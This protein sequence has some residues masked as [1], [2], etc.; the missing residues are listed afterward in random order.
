MKAIITY[1][2]ISMVGSLSLMAQDS[3]SLQQAILTGLENNFQIR[4]SELEHEIAENDNSWGNAGRY[5][6]IAFNFNS[7]NSSTEMLDSVGVVVDGESYMVKYD[8]QQRFAQ[9]VSVGLNWTVFNGFRVNITK[10]KL[11]DLERISEGNA[12]I[13]VENTLQ[14]ILLA[15]YGALLQKEALDVLEEVKTLSRDRYNYEL[16]RKQFGTAV[17][18]DVLQ[19]QNN[20]LSDSAN[21][22]NQQI[23]YKNALRNLNLVL[24]EPIDK[25]YELSSRFDVREEEFVMADLIT[26]LESSNKTLQNQFINQEILKKNVKLN[27]S[28]LYPVVSIN[29]NLSQSFVGS[30]GDYEKGVWNNPYMYDVNLALSYTLSDGGNVRRAIHNARINQEIGELRLEDMRRSLYNQLFKTLEQYEIKKQL[31]HVSETSIESA[32]LNLQIA[33]EKYRSGAISS[34][35]YRDIQI[36]YLNAARDLIQSNYNLIDSH[37][38]LMRL[39][40][41]IVTEYGTN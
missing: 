11:A 14:S 20:Y 17:T 37:T 27:Q 32:R 3:L 28:R 23:N 41:G 22:L 2:F 26:K 38:E 9:S 18:F 31:R 16:S 15:Y 1:I 39:T 21:A 36:I 40:G 24:A 34:F 12:A 7:Q 4:I 19:A 30:F 10:A 29:S 13:V 6:T 35:N 8:E 5:P 33:E 25:N